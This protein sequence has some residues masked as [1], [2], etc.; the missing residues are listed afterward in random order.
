[1]REHCPSTGMPPARAVLHESRVGGI[2]G[3]S[4]RD[5]LNQ[6][7]AHHTGQSVDKVAKDTDRDFIMSAEEA[8]EYGILD[9]VIVS[10]E[11]A[12]VPQVAGV[13]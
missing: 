10:R 1:M 12:R 2:S 4:R 5:L 7:L 8:R 3:A 6:I 9:E 13:S 11:L